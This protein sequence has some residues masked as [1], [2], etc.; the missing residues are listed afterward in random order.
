MH[1]YMIHKLFEQ[2]NGFPQDRIYEFYRCLNTDFNRYLMFNDKT[3]DFFKVQTKEV[4]QT[5][6]PVF[7]SVNGRSRDPGPFNLC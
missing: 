6:K 7:K 2:P 4:P 5:L 1:G 3:L